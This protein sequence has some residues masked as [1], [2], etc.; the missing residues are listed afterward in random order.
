MSHTILVV[1]DYDDTRELMCF[2]LEREGYRVLEAQDGAKAFETVKRELPDLILMD[3][4][5][6]VLDGITATKLIKANQAISDI[7][8][9]SVTAHDED[10]RRLAIAAGC[11]ET[12]GKPVEFENLK[13][14]IHKYLPA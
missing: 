3:L 5:L 6:P 1:E 2:L 12:I 10:H 9:V 7:P 13:A 11:C 4:S 8:I 14:V